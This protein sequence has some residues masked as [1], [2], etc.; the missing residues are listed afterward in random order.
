MSE[1]F[2]SHEPFRSVKF[3]AK[4]LGGVGNGNGSWTLLGI[5]MAL[6]PAH[7]PCG[8]F[9][10]QWS[11]V[12]IHKSPRMVDK[13]QHYLLCIIKR[14]FNLAI[15]V[16]DPSSVLKMGGLF[17]DNWQ[18]TAVTGYWQQNLGFFFFGREQRLDK[19]SPNFGDIPPFDCAIL[20]I[21]FEV[22]ANI[23]KGEFLNW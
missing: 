1:V 2:F 7:C 6:L 17:H 3:S 14:L 18:S 23:L 21:F 19:S 20:T 13:R 9:S 4:I 5:G 15:S 10:G 16:L 8:S 11:S 12:S 22:S